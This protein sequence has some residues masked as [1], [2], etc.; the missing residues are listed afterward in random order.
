MTVRPQARR[1]LAAMVVLGALVLVCWRSWARP[2]H[3]PAPSKPEPDWAN[4]RY[5]PHDRNVLDLWKAKPQS[6]AA[7]PTPVVVFFHG[8]GFRQGDKSSISGW[9][10]SRCLAAGISV[11]SA[12]YRLSTT[13][14]FPAPMRDGARAVQFLRWRSG[15]LGLDPSRIAAVGNSAGA[16]I[17]LW[18]GLHDD[19]ADPRSPDP[20]ARQSTRLAC[21][22][23]DG[24][25]TSYDPRFI[26]E[27]IGGRA[28]EHP[29][30]AT[31]YGLKDRELDTPRAHTLYEEASPI[32][33]ATADDPPVVLFYSEP[34]RPLPTGAPP[35]RGIH[36]P[37]F[38]AVLK[39]RL[40]PMGV[41]CVVRHRKDLPRQE[42]PKETM[43]GEM[44]DFF[45][46]ELRR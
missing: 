33:Y 40:E 6:G 44:A 35:G 2:P 36:H 29:A 17:A 37:R 41:E 21:I 26:Q 25:Q 7:G 32:T 31:F 24:A 18:I 14:P 5:G 4:L 45:V 34:D 12:N 16:G 39:A 30:L 11:A 27:L 10:V 13:A 9:L 19:L 38:G 43:F 15:E 3:R 42:D 8:G 22:G 1:R 28:H 20:I 23:G 46:R